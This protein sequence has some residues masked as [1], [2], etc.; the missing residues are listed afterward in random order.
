MLLFQYDE[1]SPID[2]L[3]HLYLHFLLEA[4]CEI[5]IIGNEIK[6]KVNLMHQ[7]YMILYKQQLH[8]PIFIANA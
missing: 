8:S 2:Q 3:I 6:M 5:M 7:F 1:C 4:L